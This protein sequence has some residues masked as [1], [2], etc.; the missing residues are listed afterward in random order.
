MHGGH[1]GLFLDTIGKVRRTARSVLLGLVTMMMLGRF[2]SSHSMVTCSVNSAAL[3]SV[4]GGGTN[5]GSAGAR[6]SQVAGVVCILP[7]NEG[8]YSEK[9]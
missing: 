3:A 6:G 1:S 2:N 8:M 4:Q 5:G 7:E 9:H